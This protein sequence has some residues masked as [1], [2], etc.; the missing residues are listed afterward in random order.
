MSMSKRSLVFILTFEVVSLSVW[1]QKP[2]R[3]VGVLE[4]EITR[5]MKAEHVPGLSMV[6]IRNNRIVWKAAFGVRVA[7]KPEKI[8]DAT[9]FEAASMSK[10]VSSR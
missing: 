6:L 7:G 4:A 2:E 5:L 10:P 3:L 8:D 1:A 9:V